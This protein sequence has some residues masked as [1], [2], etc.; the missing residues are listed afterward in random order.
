ML[1]SGTASPGMAPTTGSA[2][3]GTNRGTISN[4]FQTFLRMLTAQMQNQNPL[5]PIEASDFAV[6]LATFSGVEQQVLTNDLLSK[7]MGR[8]GFAELGSWVGRQALADAP[9]WVERD[10]VLLVPPEVI[11]ADRAELVL[12]NLNG[13]E[14][15]RFAVDPSSTEIV[16]DPT[17]DGELQFPAGHYRFEME[18]FSGGVSLGVNPV[19]GY[20]RIQ[21][22]RMDNGEI[23]L[24]LQGGHLIAS[25]AVIGLR[26]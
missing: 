1:I 15:R 8:M 5:E 4:D 19:M 10:S 26:E 25:D 12:R 14:L 6:Q 21:E 9:V 22:A 13:H 2:A 23:L 24:V 17:S 3:Q 16:F 20:S 18:S 7:M 11:G